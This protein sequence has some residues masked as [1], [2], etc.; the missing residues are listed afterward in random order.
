MSGPTNKSTTV[1]YSNV[2][3]TACYYHSSNRYMCQC[4][5]PGGEVAVQATVV[6]Q[7]EDAPDCEDAGLQN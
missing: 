6:S 1:H 7:E 3:F 2:H 5:E 4:L